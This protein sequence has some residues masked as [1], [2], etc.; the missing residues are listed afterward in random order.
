M[1]RPVCTYDCLRAR[2]YDCLR[3]RDCLRAQAGLDSPQA[4]MEAARRRSSAGR[5][6]SRTTS[7]RQRGAAGGQQP[8]RQAS[9]RQRA[10]QR[11]DSESMDMGQTADILDAISGMSSIG[12]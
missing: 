4:A 12:N 7:G 5:P 2:A 9:Q 11:Y 6:P 3:A 8:Q 10:P 1:A